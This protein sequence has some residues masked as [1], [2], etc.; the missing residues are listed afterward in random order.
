LPRAQYEPKRGKLSLTLKCRSAKKAWAFRDSVAGRGHPPTSLAILVQI[1]HM[2]AF[3][4]TL[5]RICVAL[6]LSSAAELS[7]VAE[8]EY[9]DGNTFLEFRLDYLA[10]CRAGINV[11]ASLREKLPD[12][13]IVATCRH[14]QNHGHFAGS[15]ERQLS[16]L[17]DSASAGASALDLEIES[18]EQAESDLP[19]LEAEAP[20]VV[21]YHDF[22]KTPVLEPV[23]RRLVR[24]PADAYKIA[25]TAVKPSDNL[26]LIEFARRHRK[27]PLVVLAMSEMGT[28][29]RVLAPAAGSLYT[30]AA[31]RDIE[32]T[33]PG[34]ITSKAM[35]S[36]YRCDKLT[37]HSR[38]YGVIADPVAHSK[39]PLIHNRALQS[40]RIDAVYLPFLVPPSRLN[41]WMKV[42][43]ELPVCGF[44][45]TIPHKQR[46]LRH[47]DIVA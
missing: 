32:G 4:S 6:G 3:P 5:P 33:A 10:D 35:R 27:V 23:L 42:A 34:Q 2:S 41:D 20:L 11:I 12:L 38:I 19:A 26:R 28:A 18:A 40:K 45:V 7:R 14:R 44:S 43:S 37:K 30:Y 15:V 29:S 21:S 25:T 22:R 9:R 13:Q 16:I 1:V 36:L 8:Q 31:P 17:R 24:L 46:I 47:I 39:S